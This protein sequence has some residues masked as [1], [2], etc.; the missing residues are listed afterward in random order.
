MHQVLFFAALFIGIIPYSI[1]IKRKKTFDFKES[2]IPFVCLTA[3]ATLYEFF[4]SVILKINTSYWWQ[5]YSLLEFSTLYYFFYKL[6]GSS[7]KKTFLVFVIFLSFTYIL[8]FV[9]WEEKFITIAINKLPLTFFVFT[10]SFKWY[11]ELFQKM[12]IENPWQ[13]STFYFISGISIYYSSTFFLF[14]LS[15]YMFIDNGYL[16]DYW[17]INVFA[18]L[19]LRVFLI[20][21]VW[22]MRQN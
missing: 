2:I 22:K 15:K 10:F 18:T 8:S 5:L 19:I 11:R 14:L 13:N 12:D 3:I 6:F 1:L 16:Y 4:G 21:G 20:V 17:L 9:F 7:Y